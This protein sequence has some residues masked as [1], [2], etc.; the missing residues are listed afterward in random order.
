MKKRHKARGPKKLTP[1]TPMDQVA[2]SEQTTENITPQFEDINEETN[3]E[4]E[5]ES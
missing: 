4:M 5:I 3:Q 1:L 2:L